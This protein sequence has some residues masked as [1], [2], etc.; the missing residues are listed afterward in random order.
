MST[1]KLFTPINVGSCCLQHRIVLA[2]LTRC[3]AYK[4]HVHSD[5]AIEYYKQR[6]S[7]PGTLLITE[8]TFISPQAGGFDNVP[9]VWDEAQVAAWKK[10]RAISSQGLTISQRYVAIDC[11]CCPFATF[12]HLPPTLGSWTRRGSCHP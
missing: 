5:I 10:V 11:R 9:G 4:T 6:A 1:P 8:A 7:T 2:P 3:R 12:V